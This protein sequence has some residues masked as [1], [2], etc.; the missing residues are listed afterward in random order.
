MLNRTQVPEFFSSQSV[1]LKSIQ[2]QV[3]S[4]GIELY[5]LPA[6]NLEVFKIELVFDAGSLYGSKFGQS[7]FTSKLM[8]GGT[9]RMSAH[10]VLEYFDQY[11]GFVEVSQNQER[12]YVILHGLTTHFERYLELIAELIDDSVFPQ[13][14]LSTQKSINLQSFKV[15]KEKTAFLGSME[16]RK[17][18]FGDHYFGKSLDTDEINAVERQDIV[19]FYGSQ[20]SGQLFK[21][22]FSGN[23]TEQNILSISKTLGTKSLS[24]NTQVISSEI[25]G[26]YTP[27]SK[28]VVKEEAL[29]SSI[30]IGQRMFNR[31]HSDFYKFVV[32][33][34]ILGGYFGSRLMKNIREEKGFT[35]G[36]SSSLVPLVDTGYFI[37]GTDVKAENTQETI[38]E[39]H[40]EIRELQINPVTEEEL[41]LV[42]NY[43]AGSLIGGI[44]TPFEVMDKHK[45]IIFEGLD[46]NFY[47]DFIPRIQAVT[48]EDLLEAANVH[49][50]LENLSQVVVGSL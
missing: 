34:T 21:I 24:K 14:E 12:L 4:N 18:I 33:N 13:E 35:Y 27:E 6:E 10:Q 26:A 15:N 22:F 29:Q 39:I 48:S 47:A 42:K 11:G 31:K 3:L 32:L 40:K 19:D 5:L 2:K 1:N 45:A 50:R 23:F 9:S 28:V 38:D 7:F 46:G 37:I 36:I 43:M 20:V 16:I 49:L 44:N 25:P 41:G 30:R 8:L 17:L